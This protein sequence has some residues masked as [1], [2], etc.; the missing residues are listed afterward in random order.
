MN[1]F[2]CTTKSERLKELFQSRNV[3]PN[4]QPC[5]CFE[6]SIPLKLSI[7]HIKV[8]FFG[9]VFGV[10][11]VQMISWQ[12]IWSKQKNACMLAYSNIVCKKR[13]TSNL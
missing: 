1:R 12:I 8:V 6:L 3:F 5:L 13:V 9:N 11:R 10:N 7:I 4:V 2:Y